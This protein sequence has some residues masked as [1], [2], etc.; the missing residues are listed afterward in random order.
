MFMYVCESVLKPIYSNYCNCRV[1]R[2]KDS[3]VKVFGVEL[4][5]RVPSTS[6]SKEAQGCLTK[7]VTKTSLAENVSYVNGNSNLLF[8]N[9]QQL[10]CVCQ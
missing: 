9:I 2:T 1:V 6:S 5:S 7:D 8:Y 4:N 10:I 3:Q